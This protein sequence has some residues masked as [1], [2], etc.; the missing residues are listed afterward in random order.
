[1]MHNLARWCSFLGVLTFGAGCAHAESV[2]QWLAHPQR[3]GVVAHRGCWGPAPEN[4]LASLEACFGLGTEAV[5]G[6]LRTTKDGVL[7]ILHDETLDR[8]T[9][10][11][12]PLKSYSYDQIKGAVLR[13]GAGGERAPL[14]REHMPAFTEFLRA[15][16]GH[17]FLLLHLKEL[18]FDQ[19]YAAVAAEHA[20]DRVIFLPDL[21][22]KQQLGTA[23][24]LGHVAWIP[25]IWRCGTG[26]TPTACYEHFGQAVEDYD[27][28]RPAAYFP[29]SDDAA[30]LRE[31]GQLARSG[32]VRL[33]ESSNDD[34][35][36]TDAAAIWGPL[37]D[38]HVAMI[39]TNQPARVSQF[40]QS[41]GLR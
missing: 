33:L 11:S 13:T 2:A 27:S 23:H 28:L 40:L 21:G 16:R 30:F 17:V 32:R 4:S 29:V 6:D 3:P 41:R 34:D 1:M 22:T 19:V 7:V 25:F 12:G 20:E 26:P 5:E 18:N 10:L 15:A 36:T 9:N 39:L 38:W 31:S 35:L 8:T 24:F 14:T 37:I